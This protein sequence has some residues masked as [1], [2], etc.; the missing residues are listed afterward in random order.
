MLYVLVYEAKEDER[1]AELLSMAADLA[2]TIP[3]ALLRGVKGQA[4][5]RS[6][7]HMEGNVI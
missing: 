1:A 6:K 3:N 2:I 5:D 7:R 4:T